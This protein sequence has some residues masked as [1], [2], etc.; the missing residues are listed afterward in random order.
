[1]K[2]RISVISIITLVG[3]IYLYAQIPSFAGAKAVASF[4]LEEVC[5]IESC[6]E[7]RY[8]EGQTVPDEELDYSDMWIKNHVTEIEFAYDEPV[9][10]K[11][12]AR[13]GQL[14]NLKRLH[15]HISGEGEIDLSPLGSLINL[16]KLSVDAWG[17]APDVSFLKDLNQLR[18]ISIHKLCELEDLSVF[19][20]KPYL[21]E[22]RVSYVEDVD[23][24]ELAELEELKMIDIVG[25]NIRNAEG[26]SNLVHLEYLSLNDNSQYIEKSTFDLYALTGLVEL[27]SISLLYINVDDTSPLSGLKCLR[28]VLISGSQGA[29]QKADQN[30]PEIEVSQDSIVKVKLQS[31]EEYQAF[32]GCLEEYQDYGVLRMDLA[33]TDTVIYLDEILAYGNF[34]ILRI[35]NG[36]TVLVRDIET[37]KENPVRDIELYHPYAIEENILDQIHTLQDITIRINSWYTGVLPAKELLYDTDCNNIVLIWDDNRKDEMFL[38]ELAEW[39]EINTI[40]LEDD[41]YL[42]GIYVL[43]EDDYN[44]VSYEFCSCGKET[45]NTCEAKECE[46][47]IC[48]KDRESYGEKYFDILEIPIE[49]IDTLSWLDGRRIRLEDINF[50]GYRDLVFVGDNDLSGHQ[51]RCIGF[52]WNKKKQ[53]Y[54][55]NA[56]VPKDF[57]WIDAEQKRITCIYSASA[58]ED[59]RIYEYNGSIF[60]EK[61]LE[62][63]WSETDYYRITWQYYEEGKLLK[64]LEENYDEDAKQYYITYEENGIVTEEVID[65]KDYKYVDHL[66]LGKEYFP[67]FDF[68][69]HG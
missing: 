8:L 6:Q 28:Y 31:M 11:D 37:L 44:Y 33:E 22:L 66:D 69:F 10:Q 55:W 21:Q 68:Y 23:L 59:Y 42:K 17:M 43:N 54:E 47:F 63:I 1:M 50:D 7:K 60:T 3:C 2:K 5:S 67:E 13:I 57:D 29:D 27:K 39:E 51:G 24:N 15:I 62:V 14:Q 40:L 49:N 64:R 48:I 41:S 9:T 65:K 18:S 20:E 35:K 52:L 38:E 16:R 53:K 36:G 4:N 45:G 32:V 58:F 25:G 61:R 34:K 30:L 56:T 12:V 26:L 19:R 46:S